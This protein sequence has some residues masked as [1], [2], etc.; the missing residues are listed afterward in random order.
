[1]RIP[2]VCTQPRRRA[3][4]S[5]RDERKQGKNGV[6]EGGGLGRVVGRRGEGRKEEV[7]QKS[8]NDYSHSNKWQPTYK[9]CWYGAWVTYWPSRPSETFKSA[10]R[11]FHDVW[12]QVAGLGAEM[13]VGTL[14]CDEHSIESPT[15]K[16]EKGIGRSKKLFGAAKRSS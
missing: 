5:T 3:R 4:C 11:S 12:M 7:I 10:R 1:M 6:F 2:S 15:M 13:L 8:F 14:S 16:S 9:L